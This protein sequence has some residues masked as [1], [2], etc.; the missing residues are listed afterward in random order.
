[1]QI[2]ITEALAKLTE[3][4]KLFVEL[5][6]HGSL[7]VEVYKPSGTDNQQPHN[8]DEVYVIISGN[9]DF[10]NGT[11]ITPFQKGDFL[12]VPAGVEHRFL[13]FS[14]DFSTWVIFYGPDGGEK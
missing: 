10:L 3:Q 5:F 11:T 8:K 6:R 13:N 4:H 2:T 14:K 7:S 1:M 9:G 12:F